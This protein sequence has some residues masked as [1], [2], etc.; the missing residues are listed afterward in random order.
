M[1][2]PRA[3]EGKSDDLGHFERWV[4]RPLAKNEDNAASSDTLA[5]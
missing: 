5:P 3:N 4:L 2:F 1:A